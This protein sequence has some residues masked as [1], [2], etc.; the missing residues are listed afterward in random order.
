MFDAIV[1]TSVVGFASIVRAAKISW[2]LT[3]RENRVSLEG[4]G[5][6]FNETENNRDVGALDGDHGTVGG[7]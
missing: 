6:R 2:D 5:T 7:W 1:D 3:A 4:E